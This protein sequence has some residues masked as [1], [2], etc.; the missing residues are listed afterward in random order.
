VVRSQDAGCSTT[1]GLCPLVTIYR[2]RASRYAA[3]TI[4]AGYHPRLAACP[5]SDPAT[6]A[7]LPPEGAGQTFAHGR[8]AG[9]DDGQYGIFKP[10]SAFAFPRSTRRCA[11]KLRSDQQI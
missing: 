9:A 5:D 10:S 8:E 7:W 4:T 6:T 1:A 2:R 11:P 3:I